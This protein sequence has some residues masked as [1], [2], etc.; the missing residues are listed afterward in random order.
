MSRTVFAR[1]RGSNFAPT[2]E[3]EDQ[4]WDR[5]SGTGP[6]SVIPLTSHAG[7][8]CRILGE[9]NLLVQE[10]PERT[11]ERDMV[12]RI[13]A[14]KWRGRL[15]FWPC[16]R[17]LGGSQLARWFLTRCYLRDGF[18]YVEPRGSGPPFVREAN[19]QSGRHISSKVGFFFGLPSKCQVWLNH[20]KPWFLFCKWLISVLKSTC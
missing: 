8:L 17:K 19:A 12:V 5:S 14:W 3:A 4:S 10:D 7:P 9:F 13:G 16:R 6:R 1:S 18:P 11:H 20:S 15:S 2:N